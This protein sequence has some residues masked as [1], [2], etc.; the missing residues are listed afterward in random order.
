MLVYL[1]CWDCIYIYWILFNSMLRNIILLNS[2]STVA[3]KPIVH[4][5]IVHHIALRLAI[6]QLFFL[7]NL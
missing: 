1:F 2:A 6:Y 5:Q 7:Q 3:S 4:K